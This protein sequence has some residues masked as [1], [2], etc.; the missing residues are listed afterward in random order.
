MSPALLSK[1]LKDL[2]AAGVVER[3]RLVDEPGVFEYRLTEAG[4]SLKPVVEAVGVWGQRWIE[5]ELSLENLDP[6]LLMWDMRRNINPK[7]MPKRRTVIQVIF[8]DIDMPKGSMNGLKLAHAVHERWPKIKIILVSGQLTLTDA[9]KPADSRFYGKPLEVKAMIAEMQDMMGKGAL[10][11]IPG[12]IATL[13]K[14]APHPESIR[15]AARL[16]TSA[17]TA[18]E[19]LTAEK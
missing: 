11:I 9:D 16:G 8:T 2:E 15:K 12:D 18:Q 1:R 14:K 19:F 17:A 4:R 5:T 13:I 6:N 3:S 10:E 7:P